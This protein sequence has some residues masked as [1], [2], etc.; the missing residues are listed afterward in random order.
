MLESARAIE[1]RDQ[2]NDQKAT[3]RRPVR[4]IKLIPE[5]NEFT[6]IAERRSV[7]EWRRRGKIVESKLS[8]L[9]VACSYSPRAAETEAITN[10]NCCALVSGETAENGSHVRRDYWR[11]YPCAG[12]CVGD[13]L[14]GLT[15]YQLKVQINS[16]VRRGNVRLGGL[17]SLSAQRYSPV[18]RK[19]H[20]CAIVTCVR[21]CPV[22]RAPDTWT[23]SLSQNHRLSDWA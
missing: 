15:C 1:S 5:E 4:V 2:H 3:L 13:G 19:A 8:R 17:R 18:V 23:S 10:V 16:P 9:R 7:G 6:L 21:R 11:V 20:K 14:F 22:A 12:C